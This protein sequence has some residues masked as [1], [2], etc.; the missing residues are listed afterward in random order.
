MVTLQLSPLQTWKSI[1]Q[2]EELL[3]RPGMLE[4]ERKGV[5]EGEDGQRRIREAC[6]NGSG[7]AF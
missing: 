4:S 6:R 3:P 5:S 1:R 2:R 7:R